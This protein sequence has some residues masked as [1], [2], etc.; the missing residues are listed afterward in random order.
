M[1]NINIALVDD[2][3]MVISGLISLLAPYK[4]I[5]ISGTY[6]N[7]SAL[8]EGLAQKTPDVL[9]LDIMLPEMSGKELVPLIKQQFGGVKILILTSMDAPSMVTSMFRRGSLGY[10]LKGAGPG[11]LVSAIET[12]SRNEEFIDASLKEQLLQNVIRYKHDTQQT[13]IAPELTQREKEILTLIAEEFTTKEISEKLF[14]SY[15]TA[16][17]HRYNL[18]QKLDVKNT[19]G[20]VKVAIQLGLVT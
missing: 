13:F 12:V 20:L 7:G 16:E 3:P 18:I 19:A 17:N 2:H 1:T 11:L 15:R 4:H 8:L 6:S 10:L 5:H 14:I 9:I